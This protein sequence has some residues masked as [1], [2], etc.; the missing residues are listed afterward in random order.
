MKSLIKLVVSMSVLTLI[1]GC[2]G[3]G[4]QYTYKP[5]SYSSQGKNSSEAAEYCSYIAENKMNDTYDREIA[6]RRAR[7]DQQARDEERRDRESARNN[8]TTTCQNVNYGY[9]PA[10]V[11]CKTK[12]DGYGYQSSYNKQYI[13]DFSIPIIM[14][15]S[16]NYDRAY[17]D[18]MV[19]EGYKRVEVTKKRRYDPKSDEYESPKNESTWDESPRRT[20]KSSECSS[21]GSKK[22]ECYSNNSN[23]FYEGRAIKRGKVVYPLAYAQELKDKGIMPDSNENYEDFYSYTNSTKRYN[24]NQKKDWKVKIYNKSDCVEKPS[25][26]HYPYYKC[27]DGVN[28]FNGVGEIKAGKFYSIA[29]TEELEY[30]THSQE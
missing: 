5:A 27:N 8:S 2:V 6:S 12:G 7:L 3:G 1:S 25:S 17:R 9:G 16:T 21:I 10:R 15:K 29:Y 11:E 14:N 19:N 28:I 30:K 22:Y 13:S 18:C 23:N 4:P 24:A 26:S 20:Y